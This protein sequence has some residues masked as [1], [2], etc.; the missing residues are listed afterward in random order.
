M[1]CWSSKDRNQQQQQKKK[2]WKCHV[3]VV[4]VINR[5]KF[6][7]VKVSLSIPFSFYFFLYL[8]RHTHTRTLYMN[9]MQIFYCL[10][11]LLLFI[12]LIWL[13]AKSRITVNILNSSVNVH[14]L[15]KKVSEWKEIVKSNNNKENIA[16]E[17]RTFFYENCIQTLFYFDWIAQ[18]IILVSLV[19]LW[20]KTAY[21]NHFM[22]VL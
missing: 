19:E 13:V 8:H 12:N 3:N 4:V 6:I 15:K 17:Y 22:I 18:F 2:T 14:M 9:Q 1:K 16:Y 5:A 7:F 21:A 11:L 10:L 20:L